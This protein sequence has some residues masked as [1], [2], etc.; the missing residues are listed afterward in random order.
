MCVVDSLNSLTPVW[1]NSRGLVLAAPAK[2]NLHLEIL[3]KRADGYH[4]LETLMVAVDLFDTLELQAD[5]TGTLALE[6]DL[7]G[8][9]I[10]EENLV[11]RAAALLQ[12]EY[13]KPQRGVRVRLTKRIPLQAGLAGGSSD[14]AAALIG[15]NQLWKLNLNSDQLMKAAASLGSD[16]GFFLNL[17]AAWC[18][19]RGEHVSFETMKGRLD[20]V[21]ICPPVGLSTPRVFRDVLIPDVPLSGDRV[22]ESLR[23][24]NPEAMGEALHNRLQQSAFALAPMVETVYR[25]L[26][27][28][29]PAG[30]L[31]SGSGSSVF[32]LCRNRAEAVRVADGFRADRPADEPESRILIGPEFSP[33]LD[34]ALRRT[35][36][37]ITEVR[38]KLCEENN[39]R[40]LAFCSVTFDNSFVVRDLKIIE[41]TKG[42]FVAMPSRKL[43]DRC[44]KCSSKNHLRSR[45]CNA[46]GCRLDETR[47]T[48]DLDGRAK[49]H[50]DI[51]HPIHSGAREMLQ[52]TVVE[53]FHVEKDRSRQ[54]GYICTYDEFDFDGDDTP[55]SYGGMVTEMGNKNIRAHGPHPAP[56]GMH[57]RQGDSAPTAAVRGEEESFG[58]GIS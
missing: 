24:A 15:L 31:M 50:A 34:P 41:G 26:S 8:L 19:G 52:G 7:P 56:K 14:A 6:C 27:R 42:T 35:A 28:Q 55:I 20:F 9:Q 57:A 45:F 36:V 49:L 1:A 58:V 48:R 47:A 3:A 4:K 37:V 38:I 46:C 12:R 25:R 21:V 11:Y 2:L 40:L 22:R 29:K 5:D 51:A 17:P 23:A 18:K 54:P 32:A 10:G 43:T 16:V 33:D 39:E 44:V 13:G 30:C 53:A